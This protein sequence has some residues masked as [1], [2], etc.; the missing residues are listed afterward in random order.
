MK[1][2]KVIIKDQSRIEGEI[3]GGQEITSHFCR[4]GL[5]EVTTENGLSYGGFPAMVGLKVKERFDDKGNK[6][7]YLDLDDDSIKKRLTRL[8][9]RFKKIP[10]NV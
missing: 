1:V 4:E 3:F 6:S 7:L 5:Y 9:T 8:K 10:R 2:I